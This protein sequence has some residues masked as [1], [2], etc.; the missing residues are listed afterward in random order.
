MW[1][2]YGCGA[3]VPKNCTCSQE[4]EYNV[5]VDIIVTARDEDEAVRKAINEIASGGGSVDVL[6]EN[7]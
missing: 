4:K 7:G 6:E 2:C 5:T 1:K 3:S